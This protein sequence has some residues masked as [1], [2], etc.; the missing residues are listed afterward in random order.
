[1]ERNFEEDIELLRKKE[2]EFNRFYLTFVLI[3][4]GICVAGI[5]VSIFTYV[6]VAAIV[7]AVVYAA[8]K[9]ILSVELKKRFG[10]AYRLAEDG[11]E[12]SVVRD[13]KCGTDER[14]V[15]LPKR[16]MW[17]DVVALAPA[18]GNADA[19][20]T[21]LY[22]PDSVKRISAEALCEMTALCT[23]RYGGSPVNWKEVSEY[24]DTVFFVK[25]TDDADG[26]VQQ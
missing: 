5:I 9:M 18:H 13:V 11:L 1:M 21:E 22:I 20:V 4:S 25:E 23:V 15:Y 26:K 8:Y 3:C 12:V 19:N 24:G 7:F 2:K 14:A 10:I 16:I 17:L 6:F